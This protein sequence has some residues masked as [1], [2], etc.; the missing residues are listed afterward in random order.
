ME[1]LAAMHHRRVVRYVAVRVDDWVLAEDL[2]Q[3]MWLDLAMR[4]YEMDDWESREAADLYPLLAWR[5]KRQIFQYRRRRMNERE[6]LL[7]AAG[8]GR[9]VEQRLDELAGPGPGDATECAVWELLGLADSGEISGC[10]A[11]ALGALTRRQREVVELLCEGMSQ[12]AV[13]ARMGDTQ[14][15]VSMHL[16][17]ALKTLRD[18]AEIER[19]LRLQEEKRLPGE[20]ERVVERLVPSQAEVVRL[21]AGGLSNAE[22][23]DRLG[24][25]AATTQD[26]YRRAVVALRLMVQERRMD[27][28]QAAPARPQEKGA[29]HCARACAS[30]CYLRTARAGAGVSA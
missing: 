13:A 9:T 8:D 12:R 5:A 11:R 23:A 15:N 14:G 16:G 25:R 27:P 29:R 26:I 22:V 18:P 2:V 10:W 1:R 19:R 7:G 3:E 21:R 6:R 24:K 20:W 4:P 17:A 28:V 30:G